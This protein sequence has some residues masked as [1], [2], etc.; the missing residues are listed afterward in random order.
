MNSYLGML[1]WHGLY[2][3][4]KQC[5]RAGEGVMPPTDLEDRWPQIAALLDSARGHITLGRVA[6]I[7]RAAVAVN[8]HTLLATRLPVT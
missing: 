5:E 4:A 7:E 6:P 3:S 1:H 2:R 8:D